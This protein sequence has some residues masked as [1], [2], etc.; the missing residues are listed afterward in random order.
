MSD[1]LKPLA[2]NSSLITHHSSLLKLFE[3]A[4]VVLEEEAY[5]VELVHEAAHAV[6]AEAE[7][8]A[9]ELFGIDVNGAQDVRVNHPRP[10]Q[11]YPARPFAETTARAAALEAGVVGLHA[12][13][14]E[15]KIRGAEARARRGAEQTPDELGERALQVSHVRAALDEQALQLEEHR[16]VRRVGRVASED[17]TGR[18]DA[19]R[20]TPTLH[21]VNLHGRSLRAERQAVGRVESV[22]RRARRVQF[23]YVERGEVVELRLDFWAV[24]DRVA[25]RDEDVF[26]A[27]AQKR[28]R[29]QVA[30]P[31]TTTGQR[32]VNALALDAEK[33]NNKFK[34]T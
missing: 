24:L 11:F 21:R 10:A 3:E 33:I 8:E 2:F 4:H 13:L 20:R 16:V 28:Y 5:V 23:R 9:G 25:H 15:R 7:G 30:A 1:E 17:P 31:R 18:D 12:R 32:H 26:D 27:L 34:G 6:Y 29:V 14:G 19:E 22:L